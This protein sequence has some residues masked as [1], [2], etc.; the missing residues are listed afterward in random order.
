MLY[1][2]LFFYS[3]LI[4]EM[5]DEEKIINNTKVENTEKKSYYKNFIQK[6]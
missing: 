6:R 4:L 1:K 5:D 2:L 3:I